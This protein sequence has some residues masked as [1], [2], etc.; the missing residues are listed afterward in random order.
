MKYIR[1]EVLDTT[2]IEGD[3]LVVYRV[4]SALHHLLLTAA[5]AE[6]MLFSIDDKPKETA[7][8][9]KARLVKERLK[10]LHVYTDIAPDVSILTPPTPPPAVGE[11]VTSLSSPEEEVLKRLNLRVEKE[12][13]LR[14]I[15][16]V[17]DDAGPDGTELT[18]MEAKVLTLV[19][20]DERQPQGLRRAAYEKLAYLPLA[21]LS[22]LRPALTPELALRIA[23]ERCAALGA[24]P[25]NEGAG[26]IPPEWGSFVDGNDREQQ[27]L[28]VRLQVVNR[29]APPPKED[30]VLD[31]PG[32][33]AALADL[34]ASKMRDIV[35]LE[36]AF[37]ALTIRGTEPL[38]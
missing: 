21:K 35:S 25:N 29:D 32:F 33:N 31:D 14:S 19:V 7:G 24:G 22:K 1:F 27:Q 2:D 34:M 23:T 13:P 37:K 38:K 20:S 28:L 12:N 18:P 10:E 8:E 3:I 17:N 15:L 26:W 36:T 4:E 30:P 5:E 6:S 11:L 16:R 9:R